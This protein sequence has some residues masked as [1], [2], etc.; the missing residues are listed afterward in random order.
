MRTAGRARR[1]LA[2]LSCRA[3]AIR[4]GAQVLLAWSSGKDSAWTLRELRREGRFEVA[5]LLTTVNETRARV[6]MHG[7]RRELLHAQASACALAVWEVPIPEPC[8]N[9]EYERAMA[10]AM[11]LAREQGI[12]G[13][14]FGDLFLPDIRRYREERLAGTG[15]EPLFPLWGRDTRA[16]AREM[17]AAGLVAHL[18]CVDPRQVPAGLCGRRFDETLL[19][20]LPAS[21]DPCGENGEFHTFVSAGPMF[22][23]PIPVRVGERE[24]HG[25]FVFCDLERAPAA[26]V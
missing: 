10:V 3:M 4:D 14:A 16:L 24:E 17:I 8:S 25:G 12:A 23:Q 7:V 20:E 5:A 13:V 19:A 2:P 15:L 22:E 18:T 9:A 11:G 26:K 1:K 6:A 21:A